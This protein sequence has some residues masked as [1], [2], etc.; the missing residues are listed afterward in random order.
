MLVLGSMGGGEGRRKGECK[1][2]LE[3]RI[4]LGSCQSEST[5]PCF[6]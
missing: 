3:V 6:D 5:D 2:V 4:K 1:Q